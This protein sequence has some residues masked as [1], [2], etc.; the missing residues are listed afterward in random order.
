MKFANKIFNLKI[1]KKFKNNTNIIES[2][3]NI[4]KNEK[5]KNK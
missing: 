5:R 2:F 3:N 1:L 4:N